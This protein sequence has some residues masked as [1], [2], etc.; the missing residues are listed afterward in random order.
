MLKNERKTIL[1]VEDEALVALSEES[2]LQDGG[3][4]VITVNSGEKAVEAAGKNTSIDLVLMD[5][6]L[7]KGKMDGTEAAE[8]ILKLRNLPIVFCTGHGEKAMVD[9][10]KGITRYGYVLKSSGEFVLL[11]AVLMAF[12]LFEAHEHT[13]RENAHRKEAEQEK[14]RQLQHI[15]FLAD[16]ALS[17]IDLQ[18]E[19][20]VY[21][22]ITRCLKELLPDTYITVNSVDIQKGILRTE[23]VEGLGGLSDTIISMLGLNPVGKTYALD[24][25]ITDLHTGKLEKFSK[26]LYELTFGGIPRHICASIEKV[27]QIKH[28]YGIGFMVDKKLYATASFFFPKG[29]NLQNAEIV[30]AFVHQASIAL[31]R[32]KIEKD[33]WENRRRLRLFVDSNTDFCFLKD[34]DLRYTMCNAAN[35]RFFGKEIEAILGK[36]DQELMPAVAAGECAKTD[37]LAMESDTVTVSIEEVGERVFETRKMPVVEDGRIIGVAGNIRDITDRKRAE[38]MVRKLLQ[39]KELLLKETRHRVKNHMY[40]IYNYLSIQAFMM[41]DSAGKNVLEDAANRAQFMIVLYDRLYSYENQ[42]L[43]NV[44]EFLPPLIEEMIRLFPGDLEVQ[45]KI[46]VEEMYLSYKILSPLGIILNELITNSMKHAFH[47]RAN[48]LIHVDMHIKD[49]LVV[50]IYGDNGVGLKTEEVLEDSGRLG[51]RLMGLLVQQLEG[52]MNIEKQDGTKFI[53]EFPLE[54]RSKTEDLSVQKE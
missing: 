18:N 45:T 17:F 24:E 1:L 44:K 25:T 10:V 30:E 3:F 39:E 47:G 49:D 53:I 11:E 12:E 2:T 27:L 6:D 23:A 31:K 26:G 8:K 4:D 20:A 54:A 51:I 40:T 9:R 16:T 32:Q 14:E 22:Y 19:E 13:K 46:R 43:L 21:T 29:R 33:L 7:G 41:N 37:R 52:S 38:E 48:G 35:A 36:T 28:I 50:M 5:I 42:Q 34:K 15:R